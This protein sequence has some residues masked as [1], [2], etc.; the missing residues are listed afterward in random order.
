[1]SYICAI[2]FILCTVCAA[3]WLI[4]FQH[5]MDY[6]WMEVELAEKQLL[7]YTLLRQRAWDEQERALAQEQVEISREIYQ[8]VVAEYNLSLAKPLHRIPAWILGYRPIGN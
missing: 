2:L 8:N 6:R 4:V 7:Q 3:A 1:M 5:K